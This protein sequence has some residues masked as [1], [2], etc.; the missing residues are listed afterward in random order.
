MPREYVSPWNTPSREWRHSAELD[1]LMVGF[2]G[3]DGAFVMPTER[4]AGAD[5]MGRSLSRGALGWQEAAGMQMVQA[6][7]P[8]PIFPSGCGLEERR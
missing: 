4:P 7:T 3:A 2:P 8:A 6:N 1:R 5:L